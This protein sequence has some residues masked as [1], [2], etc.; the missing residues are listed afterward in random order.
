M[1]TVIPVSDG[2]LRNRHRGDRHYW[3]TQ[4]KSRPSGEPSLLLNRENHGG[5]LTLGDDGVVA[6]TFPRFC[7]PT[8]PREQRGQSCT[9]RC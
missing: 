8:H 9:C 4:R 2:R 1:D 5:R 3:S 6:W 7:A